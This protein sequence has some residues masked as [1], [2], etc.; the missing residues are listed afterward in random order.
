MEQ[1]D[2]QIN[3]NG[4][5]NEIHH[6]LLREKP[7][8]KNRDENEIHRKFSRKKPY[9]KTSQLSF[10]GEVILKDETTPK[11]NN[12]LVENPNDNKSW[13]DSLNKFTTQFKQITDYKTAEQI[14][15]EKEQ[16]LLQ[17][18]EKYTILGM[19]PLVAIS[20]SFAIIIGCSIAIVKIK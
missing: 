10:D 1:F 3:M 2:I 20:F 18:G 14:R 5:E 11:P 6:K 9:R 7:Y 19:N 4:D 16:E 8:R 15:Y 12:E 17:K 13:I